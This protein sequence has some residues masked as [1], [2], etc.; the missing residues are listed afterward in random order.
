MFIMLRSSVHH[1]PLFVVP[2]SPKIDDDLEPTWR[3]LRYPREGGDWVIHEG[4]WLLLLTALAILLIWVTE[5]EANSI[6]TRHALDKVGSVV[7]VEPDAPNLRKEWDGQLVCFAGRMKGTKLQ[8]KD[9]GFSFQG[10][11][12]QRN[13]ETLAGGCRAVQSGGARQQQACSAGKW[14]TTTDLDITSPTPMLGDFKLSP[15]LMKQLQ[16]RPLTKGLP[17]SV[18]INDKEGHTVYIREND[19]DYKFNIK[20]GGKVWYEGVGRVNLTVVAIQMKDSLIPYRF[21]KK[22]FEAALYS[23][24]LKNCTEVIHTVQRAHWVEQWKQRLNHLVPVFILIA[25]P[26]KSPTLPIVWLVV[27][28]AV[29]V[30][31]H[32]VPSAAH[33]LPEVEPWAAR[34]PKVYGYGNPYAIASITLALRLVA[35]LLF[36]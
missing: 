31:L 36:R 26:L 18:A 24:G 34:V 19:A 27:T 4:V 33:L 12:L 22:T 30:A 11:R 10:L 1:L 15:P 8:D 23:F 7:P 21:P 17:D 25:L 14:E 13:K 35:H 28:I 16:L 29:L 20:G 5:M 3:S 32:P 9:T 2:M 6:V